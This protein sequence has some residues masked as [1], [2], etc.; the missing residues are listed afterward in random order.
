[1]QPL[2]YFAVRRQICGLVS[3]CHRFSYKQMT[4]HGKPGSLLG[5]LQWVEKA[6]HAFISNPLLL[7][8]NLA[9]GIVSLYDLERFTKLLT[10]FSC[11]WIK[12]AAGAAHCWA[13]GHFDGLQTDVETPVLFRAWLNNSH[14][15]LCLEVV[16]ALFIAIHTRAMRFEGSRLGFPLG[17]ERRVAKLLAMSLVALPWFLST[18]C[19][20][21]F[22]MESLSPKIAIQGYHEGYTEHLPFWVS[23]TENLAARNSGKWTTR[24]PVPTGTN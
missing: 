4:N 5:W 3:I 11:P 17:S 9:T 15:F 23:W 13:A 24:L 14:S 10:N 20:T 22:T 8:W 16:Y 6:E 1:M 2:A 12:V 18:H 19:P 7:A 21:H